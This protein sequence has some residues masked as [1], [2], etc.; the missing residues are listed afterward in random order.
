MRI[1][2]A[3]SETELLN[4]IARWAGFPEKTRRQLPAIELLALASGIELREFVRA[5]STL[6]YRRTITSYKPSIEH[7]C[8]ENKDMLFISGMRL[9]RKGAYFCKS[10]ID[11]DHLNDGMAYW[12]RD[13]QL[14]GV[15]V[16]TIHADPLHHI[17][18]DS[19]FL[20]SPY[21]FIKLSKVISVELATS[22]NNN[23][24]T[25][26]FLAIGRALMFNPAPIAP[27][28]AKLALRR[29]ISE[30]GLRTHCGNSGSALVSDYILQA[31]PHTWLE[32]IIPGLTK[33]K[34]NTVFHKIDGISNFSKSSSSSA[35]YLLVVAAI[36]FSAEEAL[37]TLKSGTLAPLRH[38]EKIRNDIYLDLRNRYIQSRG[39]YDLIFSDRLPEKSLMLNFIKSLGFPDLPDNGNSS[40]FI[41][42]RSFFSEGKSLAESVRISQVSTEK[43]E[44][45]IRQVGIH[46]NLILIEIDKN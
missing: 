16:C 31:Y 36:F 32:S 28:F 12:R 26:R 19:S 34:Q 35:A 10:C 37:Q 33:K 20:F 9:A 18:K 44:D 25:I 39:R 29:R 11:H 27:N 8:P 4:L 38:S 21:K 6:P 30:L 7:G 41:A 2:G 1:N 23:D 3:Q 40:T 13:Q 24:T 46:I 45:L 42:M 22:A 17:D 5:H 14:P 43:I 15:M